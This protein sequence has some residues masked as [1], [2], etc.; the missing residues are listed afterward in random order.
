LKVFHVIEI[1]ADGDLRQFGWER[2]IGRPHFFGLVDLI[3]P[4]RPPVPTISCKQPHVGPAHKFLNPIVCL[5]GL[6][7]VLPT[8]SDNQ[9][10]D[11][12]DIR[13]GCPIVASGQSSGFVRVQKPI[14]VKKS[15]APNFDLMARLFSFAKAKP[16][17][18]YLKHH[19]EI[20]SST[21][22]G[23]RHEL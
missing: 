18:L 21:W 15:F 8:W 23:K 6:S 5:V 7:I 1:M 16:T 22:I 3:T 4:R 11:A 12:F 17:I 19:A 14:S 2:L 9:L 13:L 10:L 20:V